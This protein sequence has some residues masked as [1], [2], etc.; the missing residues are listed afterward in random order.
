MGK[1]LQ[2]FAIRQTVSS[3]S[4]S[5]WLKRLLSFCFLCCCRGFQADGCCCFEVRTSTVVR[6]FAT[7]VTVRAV[8]ISAESLHLFCNQ[9][10]CTLKLVCMPMITFVTLLYN[11]QY[12]FCIQHNKLSYISSLSVQFRCVLCERRLCVNN[13][14]KTSVIKFGIQWHTPYIQHTGTNHFM[15]YLSRHRGLQHCLHRNIVV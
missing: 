5:S 7:A 3:S 1:I 12:S 6:R 8:K 10:C 13:V 2:A 9:M 11:R 4:K 14:R 15:Y